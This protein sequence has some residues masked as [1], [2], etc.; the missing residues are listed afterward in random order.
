M[1]LL[2][3]A[4][5]Q[6]IYMAPAD[7]IFRGDCLSEF[8]R[9]GNITIFPISAIAQS[10]EGL[11]WFYSYLL[12]PP[13]HT[14]NRKVVY[15]WQLAWTV[16]ISGGCHLGGWLVTKLV[17]NISVIL[18]FFFIFFTLLSSFLIYG[19]L[20]KNILRQLSGAPKINEE[21]PFQD[22]VGPFDAACQPF[23]IF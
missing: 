21:H 2:V 5:I 12:Q 22:P 8:F 18:L 20:K 3:Y 10:Q 13:I 6:N 19:V 16:S 23:C 1:F 11:I 9:K 4:I 7:T 14:A 15:S 17:A